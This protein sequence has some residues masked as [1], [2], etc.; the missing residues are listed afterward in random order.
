MS[1]EEFDLIDRYFRRIHSDGVSADADLL[2]GIGDDGAIFRTHFDQWVVVSDTFV[3]GHHCPLTTSAVD[4]GHKC[5]AVNLSDLAAM[6]A[7]PQY[8]ILNVALPR[9]DAQWL[10][11][12]SDGFFALAQQYGVQLIGGDTTRSEQA[13][14]SVTLMGKKQSSGFLRHYAQVGDDVWVSHAIGAGGVGLALVNAQEKTMGRDEKHSSMACVNWLNRPQPQ[15][16][17]AQA[18]GE[19]VHGAIDVSDG[20]LAECQH[21]A[22]ASQVTVTLDW[23]KIPMVDPSWHPAVALSPMELLTSGDDYQLLFT[24]SASHRQHIQ[25]LIGDH[26]IGVTDSPPSQPIG[27]VEAVLSGES[28]QVRVR[29]GQVWLEL[30]RTLGYQHGN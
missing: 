24:A 27:K 11:A 23:D 29:K 26:A 28:P 2:Q 4:I 13:V 19:K 20:L 7:Q 15:L 6:N 22:K 18:L 8:G 10:Q 21:L 5:L 16:K 12:F 1:V 9:F 17:L 25:R 14:I 3:V 30:P